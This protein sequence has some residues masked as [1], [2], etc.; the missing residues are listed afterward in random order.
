MQHQI[1]AK[2][3]LRHSV[4]FGDLRRHNTC[5]EF[6]S[7][8]PKNFAHILVRRSNLRPLLRGGSQ[9]TNLHCYH[10]FVLVRLKSNTVCALNEQGP[11]FPSPSQLVTLPQ[12]W[13][14]YLHLPDWYF[15]QYW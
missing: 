11:D 1:L 10:S 9:R 5:V 15:W 7:G 6:A 13:K 8:S 3:F 2:R 14:M 12:R 4:R